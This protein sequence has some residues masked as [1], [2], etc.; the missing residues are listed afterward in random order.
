[1]PTPYD[2]K[3]TVVRSPGAEPAFVQPPPAV[4]PDEALPEIPGYEVQREIARGA[5]GRVLAAHDLSLDREVAIKVILTGQEVN[6]AK[7]RFIR[8][9]KITARLPHPGVPPVHALGTLPDGRPFLAMKLVRGNT[10]AHLLRARSEPAPFVKIFEA[11]CQTVAFA[12]AEGVVHRDLKPANVMVGAFGEVQVMDWGLARLETSGQIAEGSRREAD[13]GSPEIGAVEADPSLDPVGVETW[14]QVNGTAG[15]EEPERTQGGQIMGTPAYMSPEQARGEVDRVGARSDVFALGVMLCEVLTGQVS[16]A[17]NSTREVLLRVAACD[18]SETHARLDSCRADAELIAIVKHC[19][20]PEPAD[21]PANGAAVADALAAYRTGVEE[22]LRQVRAE[23]A[24]AEARE[25][26]QRKRRKV[27]LAL[28]VA[29]GLLVIGGGAFTWWDD[30]KASDRRTE[31]ARIEAERIGEQKAFEVERRLKSEQTRTGVTA[32]LQQAVALGKQYRFRDAAALLD[33][34]GRLAESDA[35][36]LLPTVVQANADLAFVRELDDIRMK[37]STWIAE[38]G[39]KGHFDTAGAPPAY[40]VAFKARGFDVLVDAAVAERIAASNV[41]SELVVA[42]D[43]WATLEVDETI[44]HRVLAVAAKADVG[45]WLDRF[46]DPGVRADKSRLE[47]LARDIDAATLPPATVVALSDLMERR[48]MDPSHLLTGSLVVH[49]DDFLLVF[50][51]GRTSNSRDD[52]TNA[53]GAYRAARAIR[54][55]NIAVLNNLGNA[56][57]DK[58]ELD[59]AIACWT[60]ALRL[61]PNYAA[62]HYNLGNALRDK[63]DLDGAIAC[64]EKAI[65]LDPK[66]AY[67]HNNLGNALLD[68]KDVNG[69][70]ACYKEA[71][72]LDPRFAAAHSNLGNALRDKHDLDGAIASCKEALRLDPK[73]AM[74][75][76]HLGNALR[77]IKDLDGAIASHKEAIRLNPKFAAAHNNLGLALEDKGDADRAIVYYTEA[78]RLDPKFAVAHSNLGSVLY[79]KKNLDGAIA[80]YKEA[81]RLDP[82]NAASQS[83]L[84]LALRDNN[85]LDGAIAAYREAVRIEPKV[86]AF[87][88]NLGIALVNKGE[89]D[90]AVDCFREAVRLGPKKPRYRENVDIA[91]K[92]KA[93]RDA[94]TAPPPRAVKRRSGL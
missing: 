69:S 41:K 42:L 1:M 11:I 37:R 90:G 76:F 72:R 43:D 61:D 85:D 81:V 46:R 58:K 66:F 86:A 79:D 50:T 10:L 28:A 64:Y 93:E 78:I 75:H 87:H 32:G 59:E 3:R 14:P 63:N 38:E 57:R 73:L 34:I 23:R 70:I 89:L 29:I 94:K 77:S 39:G 33:T 67:A 62:A 49:P 47:V 18:L 84:G 16:F 52:S 44:R 8:E 13:G 40:R 19:L 68:K 24:V 25:A 6:D 60:E 26:E 54:P 74:A 9:A 56:L 31:N 7:L 45:P 65:R 12:H 71:L 80:C 4:G 55:E 48:G 15:R 5:M 21:R 51:L 35:P 30:K 82:R 20:A 2:P 88:N 17:G 91:L 27:Q 83:N 22:R 36:D 92:L 53:I